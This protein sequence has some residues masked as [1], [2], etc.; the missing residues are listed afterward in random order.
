M[1]TAAKR[2]GLEIGNRLVVPHAEQSREERRDSRHAERSE[3]AADRLADRLGRLVGAGAELS[4]EKL[5]E[6]PIGQ[7]SAV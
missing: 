4:T 2:L 6:R 5:Q 3:L 7:S 1:Q